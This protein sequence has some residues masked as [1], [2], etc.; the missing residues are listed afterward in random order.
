MY[1]GI[2]VKLDLDLDE[3]LCGITAS[4]PVTKKVV[5]PLAEE[6]LKM[7]RSPFRSSIYTYDIRHEASKLA[8]S[9][10]RKRIQGSETPGIKQKKL[11]LGDKYMMKIKGKN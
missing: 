8:Y 3:D 7:I 1:G 10:L 11:S 2:P 9:K 6:T 4:V 5:D